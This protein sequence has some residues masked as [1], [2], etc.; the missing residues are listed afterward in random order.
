MKYLFI[1]ICFLSSVQLSLAAEKEYVLQ[2]GDA[3][4]SIA[5]DGKRLNLQIGDAHYLSLNAPYVVTL[6][7]NAET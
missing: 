7:V 5:K 1:L 6:E 4:L 2:S 3:G